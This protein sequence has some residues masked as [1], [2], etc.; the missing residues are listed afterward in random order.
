MDPDNVAV[1]DPG[2]T[3][4]VVSGSRT[5]T[6]TMVVDVE[7][8]YPGVDQIA[9][10]LRTTTARA[11]ALDPAARAPPP[12]VGRAEWSTQKETPV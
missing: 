6:A 10:V 3:V 1:C 9:S 5:P 12:R 4:A 2:R 7:A 11:H 8:R